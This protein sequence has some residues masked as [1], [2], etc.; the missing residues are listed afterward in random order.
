MDRAIQKVIECYETKSDELNLHNLGLTELPELPPHI[1]KLTCPLNKLNY[2]PTLPHQLEHINCVANPIMEL[3]EIPPSIVSIHAVGC[4]LVR[5]PY[6]LSC[7][8]LKN[9][10]LAGNKLLDELPDLPNSLQF[11]GITSCGFI[12]INKLPP[13]LTT[14]DIGMSRYLIKLPDVLPPNV[15]IRSYDN[16]FLYVPVEMRCY[17]TSY[18][19][20][21]DHAPIMNTLKKIISAKKRFRKLK[22]SGQI[23]DQA[24]EMLYRPGQAGYMELIEK[25]KGK[26]IDLLKNCPA[27]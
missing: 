5:L 17:F 10:H 22:L 23:I 11:L 4:D 13:N 18:E 21:I 7:T 1:K 9:L 6:L 26:F 3:P 25:N 24:E 19:A 8:K 12:K 20:V 2:L 15:L 14:L 16:P 27:P